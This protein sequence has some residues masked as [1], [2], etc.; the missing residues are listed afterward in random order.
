[1][2]ELES[3]DRFLEIC[4]EY[5]FQ[6]PQVLRDVVYLGAR[7]YKLSQIVSESSGSH[8]TVRRYQKLLRDE[9]PEEVV[10]EIVDLVIEMG[11]S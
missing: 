6:K 1:V 2:S 5:S 11:R 8:V 3:Y 4:Q 10:S 9:L 7:G